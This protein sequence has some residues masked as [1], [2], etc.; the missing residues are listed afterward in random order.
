MARLQ[1]TGGKT[2]CN[3]RFNYTQT[4]ASCFP[5]AGGTEWGRSFWTLVLTHSQVHW[6][7]CAFVRGDERSD[8]VNQLRPR[9][10]STAALSALPTPQGL[11]MRGSYGAQYSQ[12]DMGAG[13]HHF[14]V[15]ALA[16]MTNQQ[17]EVSNELHMDPPHPP[18]A[19]PPS[20][21]RPP[22]ARRPTFLRPHC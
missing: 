11:S 10:P 14:N 21:C 9:V 12:M 13:F 4:S 16:S 7:V 2:I 20:L 17:L 8:C 19:C 3:K 15:A 22:T 18:T 5:L 6:L 1:S